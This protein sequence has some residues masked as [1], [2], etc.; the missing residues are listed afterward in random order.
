[1]GMVLWNGHLIAFMILLVLAESFPLTFSRKSHQKTLAMSSCQQFAVFN[2]LRPDAFAHKEDIRTTRQLSRIPFLQDIARRTLLIIE[3]GYTVEQLATSVLVGPTQ[4]PKLYRSVRKASMILDTPV[5]DVYVKQSSTPNAYTLAFKGRKP[6]IVITTG[7]LDLLSD[8]EILAVLGHE[9]GHL[10][11]E[12]TIWV[13]LFNV[14]IQFSDIVSPFLRSRVLLW[15]RSA[16]FSSDR[17][18]LLVAKD[19]K[20]VASVLMKIC[21]GSSKNEYTREM[22]VEAF[23]DQAEQL[24]NEAKTF[25]GDLYLSTYERFATHPLPLVRAMEL[26]KWSK[27]AQYTGLINRSTM[28]ELT[29]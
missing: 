18:A 5:P 28:A 9:L 8:D 7:L 12:H 1:M 14:M 16:E 25:G 10:K 13:T 27:S 20:V 24:R 15:Q 11:C 6:Y 2:S 3:Q 4:M 19:T 26:I 23:L 17:A 29:T 21:G 22:N